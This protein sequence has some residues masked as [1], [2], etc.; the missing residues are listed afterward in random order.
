MTWELSLLG[1]EPR[2]LLGLGSVL[3]TSLEHRTVACS[4][5]SVLGFPKTYRD[6]LACFPPLILNRP[7]GLDPG[8]QGSD[9]GR[10]LSRPNWC[11]TPGKSIGQ[12]LS[13]MSNRLLD[14][15]LAMVLCELTL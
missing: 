7:D 14:Q 11:G 12:P 15:H 5:N 8:V 2:A 10:D 6:V 1:R 9:P 13:G 4:Q 3:E